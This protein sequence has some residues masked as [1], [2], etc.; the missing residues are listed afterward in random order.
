MKKSIF[1]FFLACFLMLG[2]GISLNALA[3]ATLNIGDDCGNGNGT[4]QDSS[5]APYNDATK[6]TCKSLGLCID[7]PGGT[8]QCCKAVSASAPSGGTPASSGGSEDLGNLSPVGKIGI[9]QL[10]GIIVAG[11]LGVVGSISLL[12][13]VYGGFLMLV[14]QGDPQKIQKGKA[15]MVW[16]TIGL[17][18]IFG[19]YI[20][21]S[22]IISGLGGSSLTGAKTSYP[23]PPTTPQ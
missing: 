6:Y 17:V 22:Y 4:C 23:A 20:L 12:V 7:V 2:M 15:T 8:T 10:I 16:A 19:S 9:P 11:A 1:I 3:A 14:S 13:F 18:V 5:K 21:V